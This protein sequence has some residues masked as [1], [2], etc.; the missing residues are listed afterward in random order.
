MLRDFVFFFIFPVLLLD[1]GF[2]YASVDQEAT[3]FR[4][5]TARQPGNPKDK[6]RLHFFFRYLFLED[7]C[8]IFESKQNGS[9]IV[10]IWI[11]FFF[12]NF[13]IVDFGRCN[14][15]CVLDSTYT[16]CLATYDEQTLKKTW[17]VLLLFPW[18]FFVAFVRM[19]VV[20]LSV[21]LLI[22]CL[23]SG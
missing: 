5:T 19:P 18:F 23:F 12:L 14:L 9:I 2:L 11:I 1:G 13:E 16:R 7:F 22:F 8:I 10:Y 20:S 6:G 4:K 3:W 15:E 21:C 17:T